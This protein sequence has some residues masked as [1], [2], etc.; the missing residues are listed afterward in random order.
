[1]IPFCHSGTLVLVVLKYGRAVHLHAVQPIINA[2]NSPWPEGV[3]RSRFCSAVPVAL[4]EC[5]EEQKGAKGLL[6]LHNKDLTHVDLFLWSDPG[7]VHTLR[8]SL[9]TGY[10]SKH[11][12]RLVS[13]SALLCNK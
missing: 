9:H 1:M 8:H 2:R 5:L 7:I 3:T 6:W 11:S 10:W 12:W 4:A 13:F